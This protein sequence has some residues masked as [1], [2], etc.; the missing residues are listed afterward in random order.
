VELRVGSFL[1][2]G[3]LCIGAP[4]LREFVEL[5]SLAAATTRGIETLSLIRE[6]EAIRQ[7]GGSVRLEIEGMA[8][9]WD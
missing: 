4:A 8:F 7:M 2:V 6:L 5:K 3:R 9:D 1:L